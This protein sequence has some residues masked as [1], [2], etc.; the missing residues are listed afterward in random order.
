MALAVVPQ[1]IIIPFK[2]ERAGITACLIIEVLLP[3]RVLRGAHT[4]PLLREAP[5]TMIIHLVRCLG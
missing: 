3:L 1:Q 5:K 2:W 4:H